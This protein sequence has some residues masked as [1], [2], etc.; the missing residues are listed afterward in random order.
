[1]D[2]IKKMEIYEKKNFKK[3]LKILNIKNK[4]NIEFIKTNNIKLL[5][6]YDKNNI[7]KIKGTFNFYGIYQQNTNLFIWASSLVGINKEVLNR[8]NNI[9]SFNHLFENNNNEKMLFFY[10][11]LNQDILYIKDKNKL[12]WINELLIYLSND[13]YYFNPLNINNNNI[14]FITLSKII[15]KYL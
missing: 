6:L 2:L 15:E 5:C 10:Q 3:I 1:M 11:L 12:Q 14:Q 13:L 8:I 9:K 7:L 4:Y